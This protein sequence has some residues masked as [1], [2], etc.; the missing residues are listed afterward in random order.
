MESRAWQQSVELQWR[1]SAAQDE[2]FSAAWAA[3]VSR[4]MVKRVGDAAQEGAQPKPM[5]GRAAS[6]IKMGGGSKVWDS[7]YN[8]DED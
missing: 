8:H 2:G 1:Q 3:C 4:W 6:L 7:S 5:G